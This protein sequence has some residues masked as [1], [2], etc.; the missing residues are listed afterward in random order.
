MLP[1]MEEFGIATAE[2]VDVETMAER[3]RQ[4]VV[5]GET[6]ACPAAPCNRLGTA[7]EL[8]Q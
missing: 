1:L 8:N 3:V 2:E 6:S 7:C 4:E 5:N